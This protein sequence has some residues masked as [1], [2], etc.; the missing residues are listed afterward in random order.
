[1]IMT[2]P[3]P[4]KKEE[5]TTRRFREIPDEMVADIMNGMAFALRISP[6]QFARVTVMMARVAIAP[7]LQEIREHDCNRNTQTDD[8]GTED[9]ADTGE[10]EVRKP[11]QTTPEA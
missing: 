4:P 6:A 3:D 11:N 8:R 1:M 5:Q 9:G 2:N 7:V 10:G